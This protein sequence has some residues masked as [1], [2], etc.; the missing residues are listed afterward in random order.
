MVRINGLLYGRKMAFLVL[1]PI[2]G[3]GKTGACCHDIGDKNSQQQT[4]Q[5]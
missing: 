2:G 5:L 1:K 4:H 3:R